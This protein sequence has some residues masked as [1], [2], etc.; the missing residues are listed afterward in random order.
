MIARR[1]FLASCLALA[2][3]PAIVRAGSLMPVRS[4]VPFYVPSYLTDSNT[5]WVISDSPLGA[6]SQRVFVNSGGYFRTIKE[7]LEH[8]RSDQYTIVVASGHVEPVS[9]CSISL[10]SAQ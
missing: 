8:C 1:S 2:C 10:G 6:E 7:A 9:S 5:F 3:A 4:I